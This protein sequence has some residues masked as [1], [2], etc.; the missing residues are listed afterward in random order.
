MFYADTYYVDTTLSSVFYSAVQ[1]LDKASIFSWTTYTGT[2]TAINNMCMTLGIVSPPLAVLLTYWT[3]ISV[4]YIIID[5]VLETFI[6][7]THWINDKM[8]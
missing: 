3:L 7:L 8:I 5:I 1:E 6:Y 4:I 2:Y